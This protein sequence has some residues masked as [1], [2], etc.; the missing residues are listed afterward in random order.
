ML[1]ASSRD[2]A[3]SVTRATFFP[4]G[5]FCL[6]T[7]LKLQVRGLPQLKVSSDWPPPVWRHGKSAQRRALAA[8]T[9]TLQ[10]PESPAKPG[11]PSAGDPG[12]RTE[13]SETVIFRPQIKENSGSVWSTAGL[14]EDEETANG[15]AAPCSSQT[16]TLIYNLHPGC[17]HTLKVSGVL[18]S[19]WHARS[20]SH[21]RLSLISL[22]VTYP[23][24]CKQKEDWH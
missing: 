19:T 11:L 13:E 8:S 10:L 12:K 4:Q 24:C 5:T 9:V 3:N 21:F 14:K 6:P 1:H 7:S 15:Q 17:F 18:T 2:P 20:F 22:T 16:S 23:F